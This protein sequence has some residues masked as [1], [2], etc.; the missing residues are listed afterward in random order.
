MSAYLV[1][2]EH[3]DALVRF[4]C[5]DNRVWTEEAEG[6]WRYLSREDADWLGR[7]LWIEN[8]VSVA[9]RYPNDRGSDRP[10]P[11]GLSDDE[12]AAYT[13]PAHLWVRPTAPAVAILK[14]ADCLDYQSCEHPGWESSK[15]KAL[16]DAIRRA[17]WQHVPGYEEAPWGSPWGIGQEAR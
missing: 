2:R 9:Y 6:G 15:A 10:G 8:L 17:A 11:C 12:I 1:D 16:L 3:I 14:S 5:D 4:A 7:V 13:F